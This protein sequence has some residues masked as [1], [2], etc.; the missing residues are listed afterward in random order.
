MSTQA[1]D[2]EIPFVLPTTR[3]GF[4]QLFAELFSETMSNPDNAAL[5]A[6]TI[7]AASH[8]ALLGRIGERLR[9]QRKPVVV[10]EAYDDAW[11]CTVQGGLNGT[12]TVLIEE[13]LDGIWTKLKAED[14]L[15]QKASGLVLSQTAVPGDVFYLTDSLRIEAARESYVDAYMA[16]LEKEQAAA[17]DAPHLKAIAQFSEATAAA[18]A[19]G[20]ATGAEVQSE[21][22]DL[23]KEA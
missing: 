22:G 5:L 17:Q 8:N 21:V 16:H 7:T 3:A 13:Q 1:A 4:K 10:R 11:K 23:Q 15:Y 9:E 6:K 19:T 14:S 2:Q 12:L 20:T 18:E